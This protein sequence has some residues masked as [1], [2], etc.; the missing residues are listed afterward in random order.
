MKQTE[1]LPRS[2]SVDYYAPLTRTL[3][4]IHSGERSMTSQETA[5]KETRTPREYTWKIINTRIFVT[6]S[7]NAGFSWQWPLPLFIPGVTTGNF[8]CVNNARCQY[9]MAR[10]RLATVTG[11]HATARRPGSV[12]SVMTKQSK[13]LIAKGMYPKLNKPWTPKLLVECYRKKAT[14][15][16]KIKSRRV[17]VISS[18]FLPGLLA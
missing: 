8:R 18:R 13:V 5:V 1:S 17:S 2:S 10:K 6:Q 9:V 11:S 16:E 12:A 7:T 14:I 3:T 4:P 15:R